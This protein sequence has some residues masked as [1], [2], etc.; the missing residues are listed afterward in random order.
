MKKH[1]SLAFFMAA[2]TFSGVTAQ[3]KSLRFNEE[4]KFKIV[5]FTDLHYVINNEHSNQVVPECI[6]NVLETE[7]PDLVV[8]T[9]D[10]IYCSPADK[11]LQTLFQ[12]V[13]DRKIPYTVTWGNHDDEQNMNRTNLQEYAEKQPYYMGKRNW[14]IPGAC[15]FVLPVSSNKNEKP[16][17]LIYCFDSHAY[18]GIEGVKGYDWIKPEQVNWY[19]ENSR[20]YTQQNN[21]E[22]LPSVAFFHIPLPEYNMAAADENAPLVG[23]RL[24]KACAPA[25]N[26][27]M[28]TAM[29]ECG[30]VMGTFVGH[31]HD[32]D[33]AT[34]WHGILLAYGRFSGGNTEYNHLPEGNGARVIVLT[35]GERTIDTWIRLRT[36]EKV[37]PLNFPS[38]FR[39]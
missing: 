6:K 3:S 33:Y 22:P 39:K 27:G 12:P 9:G 8:F 11:A 35:E 37:Q 14:D 16:A 30:D 28:F 24:E 34:A 1:L 5:Q 36:G 2:T 4:G 15:N 26:T 19:R 21:S 7:K 25:L 13:I 17:S 38:G 29:K 18:S 31:D 32:N 20:R 23:Y 10:L